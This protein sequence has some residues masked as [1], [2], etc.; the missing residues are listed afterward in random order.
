MIVFGDRFMYM[1]MVYFPLFSFVIYYVYLGEIDGFGWHVCMR[2]YKVGGLILSRFGDTTIV[3]E[4][5]YILYF[6]FESC[7]ASL[8]SLGCGRTYVK[9]TGHARFSV[10]L[11][12]YFRKL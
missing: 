7:M 11:F 1:L 3:V 6:L 8:P 5:L 4:M 9:P 2:S 12:A 10:E